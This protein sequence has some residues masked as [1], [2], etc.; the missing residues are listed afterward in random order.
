MSKRLTAKR[1]GYH[2]FDIV[3][4]IL[5]GLAVCAFL[6]GFAIYQSEPQWGKTVL[7]ISGIASVALG[8]VLLFNRDVRINVAL[9]L[10]SVIVGVFLFNL[11]LEIT[12]TEILPINPLYRSLQVAKTR[13][14]E[15]DTRSP[16]E[17]ILDLRQKGQDAYPAIGSLGLS[18]NFP[19][20]DTALFPV[21]GIANV[22]TVL[23]NENGSYVIYK[24][25]RYGFNN[26]NAVYDRSRIDVLL[27]GD[28]YT[29]GFCVERPQTIAG[30]LN[31]RGLHTLSLGIA[32]QGPLLELAALKEYG[33]LRKPKIVVWVWYQG[34]DL[35]E[36]KDEIKNPVLAKYL[37]DGF[38]QDL[39]RHQREIDAFRKKQIGEIVNEPIS[40]D[41]Y[42]NSGKETKESIKGF[43]KGVATLHKTRTVLGLTKEKYIHDLTDEQ[44]ALLQ[45]VKTILQ[46]AQKTVEGW[47]GK[48]YFAYIPPYE[49]GH[50]LHS[51]AHQKLIGIC[52]D[53][54]IPFI[55][56]D[57]PYQRHDDSVL[58]GLG[59]AG[60]HLSAEGYE[61]LSSYIY[62]HVNTNATAAAP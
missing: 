34:N 20:P 39:A 21:G 47:G 61:L 55:D 57:V 22:T 40:F 45:N 38:R 53:H 31:A 46:S 25:D 28:S 18:R 54:G 14:L 11:A 13:G 56:F 33:H 12:N 29:Q 41:K 32:G 50:A 30:R 10:L 43:L 15:F 42:L 5:L 8:C 51:V 3:L 36:L 1:S 7:G 37:N 62:E 27:I 9:S 26:D 58:L 2:L 6:F 52:N 17:V 59:L 4:L 49:R 19:Y 24:S 23:C 48:L 44:K 16:S 60:H 35:E